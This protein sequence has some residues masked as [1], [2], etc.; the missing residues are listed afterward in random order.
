LT[1]ATLFS[2]THSQESL[3]RRYSRLFS[4]S[5]RWNCRLNATEQVAVAFEAD[6]VTQPPKALAQKYQ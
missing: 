5:F 3:G 4:S 1:E 6:L 2:S